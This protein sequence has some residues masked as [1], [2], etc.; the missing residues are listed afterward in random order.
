V[1]A[2]LTDG[3]AAT[4]VPT[5]SAYVPTG[6]RSSGRSRR[7]RGVA[8]PLPAMLTAIGARAPKKSSR[9]PVHVLRRHFRS[10]M[11]R[12]HLAVR[13]LDAVGNVVDLTFGRHG[14]YGLGMITTPRTGATQVEGRRHVD[15]NVAF[16][17]ARRA[18][19][20]WRTLDDEVAL[21]AR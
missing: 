11:V 20:R 6:A 2:L 9:I 17:P 15:A 14:T 10:P 8:V 18:L 1:S 12:S 7:R 3:E 21:M 4:G 13:D 5:S 16:V 19:G